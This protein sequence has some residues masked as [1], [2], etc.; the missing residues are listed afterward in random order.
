MTHK[1]W[2]VP[3]SGERPEQSADLLDQ[4][5]I[6]RN[7][8]SESKL[9]RTAHLSGPLPATNEFTLVHCYQASPPTNLPIHPWS[10]LCAPNHSQYKSQILGQKPLHLSRT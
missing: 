2:L 8:P 5:R 6:R 3:R 4:V 10:P 1:S 9:N 7:I